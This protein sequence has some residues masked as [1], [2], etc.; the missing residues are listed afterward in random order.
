MSAHPLFCEDVERGDIHNSRLS[1]AMQAQTIAP[2]M[3]LMVNASVFAVVQASSF[4]SPADG[5]AHNVANRM[6]RCGNGLRRTLGL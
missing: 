4:V 5:V 6:M 1:L 2:N 3:Q